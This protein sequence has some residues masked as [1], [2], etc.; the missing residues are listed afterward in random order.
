MYDPKEIV[1]FKCKVK[2]LFYSMVKICLNEKY[3][4]RYESSLQN[5]LKILPTIYQNK[6]N[7]PG[8]SSKFLV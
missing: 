3:F 8:K 2:W 5:V 6:A 4:Y 1:Q 7:V